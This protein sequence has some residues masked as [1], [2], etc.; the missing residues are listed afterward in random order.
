MMGSR[1]E[2]RRGRGG[3]RRKEEERGGE[4]R[5]REGDRWRGKVVVEGLSRRKGGGESKERRG[6]GDWNLRI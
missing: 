6:V 2:G 1:D 3:G 5:G 4:E